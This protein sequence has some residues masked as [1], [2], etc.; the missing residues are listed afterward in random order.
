MILLLYVVLTILF[1]AAGYRLAAVWA[2]G[3]LAFSERLAVGYLLSGL[4]VYLVVAGIGPFFLD[5]RTSLAAAAV[6]LVLATWSAPVLAH[7]VRARIAVVP[8]AWAEMRSPT[9]VLVIVV[10]AIAGIAILQGMAPPNTYDS[11]QYHLPLAKY[12]VEV[13]RLTTQWREASFFSF[14]PQYMAH[15]SRLWL[16]LDPV[17]GLT[18]MMHG[19]VAVIAAIGAAGLARRMTLSVVGAWLAALLVLSNRAVV[20][21]SAT[22]ETDTVLAGVV[23]I[24]MVVFLAWRERRNVA[25]A[26]LFGALMGVGVLVKYHGLAVGLAMA[27]VALWELARRPKISVVP[28]A[29]AGVAALLVAAPHLVRNIVLVGNPVFPLFNGFFNPD[30]RTFLDEAAAQFGTGRELWDLAVAPWMLSIRPTKFF[31]GMAFGAPYLLALAPLA[32]LRRPALKHWAVL[33]VPAAAYFVIWFYLLS[34]QVRFLLPILPLLV[35]FAAAGAESL[36]QPGIARVAKIAAVLPLVAL[37][38]VQTLF[39]G[40]YAAL[41]LP[42]AFGIV[43]PKTYL[44]GTPTMNGAN[45]AVCRFVTESLRPGE[46]YLSF[47]SVRFYCPQASAERIDFA[48]DPKYWLWSNDENISEK[49]VRDRFIAA[50]FRFVVAQIEYDPACPG[51]P[52]CIVLKLGNEVI[53]KILRPVLARLK[54]LFVG[55]TAA[56]YDGREVTAAMRR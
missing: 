53:S 54:P 46:R 27:P 51:K 48:S 49:D 17:G 41:R 6:L 5:V 43:S 26:T 10:V 45:Y 23:A 33:L 25:V 50:D 52:G 1:L 37:I 38:G 18:Q 32:L 30:Q 4:V 8:D 31:D 2:G 7:D 29:A 12:D 16:M 47:L 13:G 21:Q 35:V 34:E 24:S 20:W 42:P 3:A 36:F 14:F 11:L 15:Q 55:P 44:D 28:L 40:I 39:V 9:K 22:A 19:N 56:V